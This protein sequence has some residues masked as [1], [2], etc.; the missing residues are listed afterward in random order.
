MNSVLNSYSKQCTESKLSQVHSAPTLGPACAHT[1]CAL[2][3]VAGLA[4]PCRRLGPAVSQAWPGRVAAHAQSC[5][6]HRRCCAPYRKL[7]G[8]IACLQCVCSAPAPCRRALGVILQPWLRCIATQSHPP[9]QRY[10]IL[11]RGPPLARPLAVL[12]PKRLPPSHDT[13]LYRDSPWP[14]HARTRY[15]TPCAQADRVVVYIVALPRRVVGVAWP[16]RGPCNYA[17]L[18][19][20]TIHPL[21][22][23]SNG[24]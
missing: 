8:R 19:C 4:R 23:D 14:G 20:V 12:R 18:P 24:Q 2:R 16:Y 9:Q 21:Y 5:R 7:L 6:V 11:Y 1:T 3:R 10:K 22:R 17:Q 15:R 13:N